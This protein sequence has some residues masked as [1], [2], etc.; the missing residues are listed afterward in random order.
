MLELCFGAQDALIT[1][2]ARSLDFSFWVFLPNELPIYLIWCWFRLV[3]SRTLGINIYLLMV[4][5]LRPYSGSHFFQIYDFFPP[6]CSRPSRSSPSLELVRKR[7]RPDL[8]RVRT[9]VRQPSP[10]QHPHQVA[11]SCSKLT[12]FPPRE[13]SS[14]NLV[15]IPWFSVLLAIV[16][17]D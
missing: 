15:A 3:F 10:S 13:K 17:V 4:S 2:L 11:R 14:V 12:Q 9:N 8:R 16:N 5:R 6:E 7:R 1:R